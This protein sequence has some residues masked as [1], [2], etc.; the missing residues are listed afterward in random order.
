MKIEFIRMTKD[1]LKQAADIYNDYVLNSTATFASET[2]SEKDME[3]ILY[4]GVAPYECYVIL[5]DSRMAGYVS[6]ESYRNRCAYD[7][8]AEL[9]VYLDRR[10]LGFGI[11]KQA[12]RFIED[13][14]KKAG[15]LCLIAVICAENERSCKLFAGCGYEKC[16]HIRDAG[17]KFGR[18]LDVVFYQ[19]I[20]DDRPQ[21]EPR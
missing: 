5:A 20:T 17:I 15:M 19:K 21:K 6:F 10:Y 16:A 3:K 18:R 1:Y 9:T 2:A 7:T 11:G 8:T 13:R 4:L 12:I 14:A